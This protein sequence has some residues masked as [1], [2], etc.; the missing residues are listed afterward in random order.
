MHCNSEHK[1]IKVSNINMDGWLV[2]TEEI[3]AGARIVFRK[4]ATLCAAMVET[5]RGNLALYRAET[6]KRKHACSIQFLSWTYRK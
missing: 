3:V 6:Y 2:S 1:D 5:C 4:R